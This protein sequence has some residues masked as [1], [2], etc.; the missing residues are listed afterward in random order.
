MANYIR[1]ENTNRGGYNPIERIVSIPSQIGATVALDELPNYAGG[2]AVGGGE[3]NGD[4]QAS[5]RPIA[6]GMELSNEIYATK[7]AMTQSVVNNT[8]N[9]N[10]NKFS[11]IERMVKNIE[12]MV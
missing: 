12:Q 8:Q 6:R 11:E 10:L 1:P 5:I 7:V 2:N 4:G 9:L 3:E